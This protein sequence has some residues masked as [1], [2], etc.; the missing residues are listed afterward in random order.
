M[1]YTAAFNYG[2]WPKDAAALT[3]SCPTVASYGARDPTLRGAAPKIERIRT[4]GAVSH[5]DAWT[6]ILV[7][8]GGHLKA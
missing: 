5:D 3:D 6:C 2:D 1:F 8:F 4:D 7:F